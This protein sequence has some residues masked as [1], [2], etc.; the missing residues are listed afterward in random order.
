MEN[1]LNP[2]GP[3]DTSLS[4]K[5]TREKILDKIGKGEDLTTGEQTIYDETIKHKTED[6]L[7]D[8]AINEKNAI[9]TP[10]Q[11]KMREKIL[12]KIAAGGIE[13]LNP[14]EK[15]IYDEVIKKRQPEIKEDLGT[16]VKDQKEEMVKVISPTGAKGSIPKSKLAAALKAGYK[17]R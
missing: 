16:F 15:K 14:G 2:P 13:S 1:T 11:K 3:E 9:E 17:K 6:D 10:N 12:E 7:L 4:K 8:N 5:T